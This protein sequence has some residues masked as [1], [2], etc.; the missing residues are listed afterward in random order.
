MIIERLNLLQP[1]VDVQLSVKQDRCLDKII[2]FGLVVRCDLTKRYLVF[3]RRDTYAYST[4]VRGIWENYKDLPNIVMQLTPEERQRLTT[5][6]FDDLWDDLWVSKDIWIY[7]QNRDRSRRRFN[8]CIQK[9]RDFINDPGIKAVDYVPEL[10]WGFPKGRPDTSESGVECAKREF[11]E[12]T[13]ISMK[14]INVLNEIGVF[15]ESFTGHDTRQ[16]VTYYYVATCPVEDVPCKIVPN[17]VVLRS[18]QETVSAEAKDV[19]W[20]YN[21]DTR[22]CPRTKCLIQKI[23]NELFL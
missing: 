23:E 19:A 13:G 15:C 16:Y 3:Q 17:G 8:Q 21:N 7:T 5:H 11:I 18:P 22:L 10:T 9:I 12:E 20:V 14:N 6:S 2:A 1:N 4:I